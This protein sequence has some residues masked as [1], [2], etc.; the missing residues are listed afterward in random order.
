M[1]RYCGK[2]RI[3]RHGPGCRRQAR[4][5]SGA[6]ASIPK[7]LDHA[8]SATPKQTSGDSLY[9][10]RHVALKA[11]LP[12]ETPALTVNR[13]CGYGHAVTCMNAAQMIPTGM[14]RNRPG[15][16]DGIDVAGA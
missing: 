14:R 13:L 6:P 3:Y 11:G 4:K 8:V 7:N 1:G 9:G 10:A 15:G 2:L 16:R 12:I 5:R